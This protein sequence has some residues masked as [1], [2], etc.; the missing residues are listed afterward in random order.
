ML[1]DMQMNISSID[2]IK[3]PIVFQWQE[4]TFFFEIA[5]SYEPITPLI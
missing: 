2:P 5:K 1:W 3:T 4:Q